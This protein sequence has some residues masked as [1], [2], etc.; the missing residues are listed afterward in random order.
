MDCMHLDPSGCMAACNGTLEPGEDCDGMDLGGHDCTEFG[1]VNPDGLA[2]TGCMLDPTG[3][4]PTCGNSVIE[5]GETCDDG[6]TV[7]GD[8]CSSTC[9]TEDGTT[10][11]NAIPIHLS[12]GQHAASASTTIGGGSHSSSTCASAGRDIVYAVTVAGADGFLT[13]TL[14]RPL[15]A[16]D[17]VLY[18]AKT[19]DDAA[20]VIALTCND[21]KPTSGNTPLFGGEVIS[22]PVTDGDT[23]FIYVDAGAAGDGGSYEVDI[24]FDENGT[25]TFPIPIPLAPGSPM[26]L[27]GTTNNSGNNTQGSCGGGPGNEVVYAITTPV[28]AGLKIATQNVD[29]NTVLYARSTCNS[30]MSE[31]ACSNFAGN[32]GNESITIPMATASTSLSLYVDGSQIPTGPANGDYQLVLTPP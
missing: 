27:L 18:A 19:C 5:P 32:G 3:C 21:S 28:T 25:C 16:F 8:G 17:S 11:A 30:G 12:P 1:F 22:F 23:W 10:C 7:S 31:L 4:H 14:P 24:R 13:A 20:P 26:T 2:C 29:Y 6:N 9:Q 15:A